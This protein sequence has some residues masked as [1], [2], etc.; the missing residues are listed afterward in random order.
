[1]RIINRHPSRGLYILL[2]SLPFIALAVAYSIGSYQRL[3][4]NPADKILPSLPQMM[5]AMMTRMRS[6]TSSA[7]VSGVS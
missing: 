7:F 4:V 6:C 3:S 5:T 1:M 2:A